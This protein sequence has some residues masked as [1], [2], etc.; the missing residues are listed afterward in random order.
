MPHTCSSPNGD[1]EFFKTACAFVLQGLRTGALTA[2]IIEKER[3][4]E[5]FKRI[6]RTDYELVETAV[7]DNQIVVRTPE[8]TYLQGGE[9]SP[10]RTLELI[11][12]F[13]SEGKRRGFTKFFGL[14][15]ASFVARGAPGSEKFFQYEAMVNRLLKGSPNH[16][17]LCV[18][19]RPI[20]P[21]KLLEEAFVV[22]GQAVPREIASPSGE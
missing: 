3:I 10:Q 11:S 17:I 4:E 5:L 22:H 7:R 13:F 12:G 1:E 14:G 21:G 8:E 2:A 6:E 15:S 18:Y 20:F 19:E 16:S 9:F